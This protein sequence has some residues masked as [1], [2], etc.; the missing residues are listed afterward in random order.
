MSHELEQ[1]RQAIARDAR[2]LTDAWVAAIVR[3]SWPLQGQAPQVAQLRER[4]GAI[5]DALGTV[6]AGR[7]PLELGAPEWREPLHLFAFTAGWMAGAELPIGAVVGLCHG[8]RELVG[9]ASAA[10]FF[11]GLLVATSEAYVAGVRPQRAAAHRAVIARSQVVCLLDE[12]LPCLFLVGDPDRQAIDDAVARLITLAVMRQA[13]AVIVDASGLIA[14]EAV[15]PEALR[16]LADHRQD[17]PP[18]VLVS[19]VAEGLVERLRV[20]EGPSG[21][22]VFGRFEDAVAAA[23]AR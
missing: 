10:P 2:A 16:I 11:D 20:V 19:T 14:P 22:A 21:R 1:L 7:P 4:C 15:L 8:L 13:D 6:L 18:R 12:R 23:A 9:A 5:L 3:R 17:P